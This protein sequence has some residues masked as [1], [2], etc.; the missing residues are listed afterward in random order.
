MSRNS[1]VETELSLETEVSLGSAHGRGRTRS[2]RQVASGT[3]GT[4][5]HTAT[6]G[7]QQKRLL[8]V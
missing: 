1:V 3:S 2:T 6:P 7:K 4:N 5:N 8:P